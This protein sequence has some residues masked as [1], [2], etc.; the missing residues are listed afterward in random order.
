MPEASNSTE[1]SEW[2]PFSN[3]QHVNM[4]IQLL[5]NEVEPW[6]SKISQFNPETIDYVL[7]LRSLALASD[8]RYGTKGAP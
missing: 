1:P 8:E 2:S 6:R 3:N 4:E 5:D 7:T